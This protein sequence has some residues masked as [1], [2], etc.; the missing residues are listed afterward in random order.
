MLMS[1]WFSVV[2]AET[3]LQLMALVSVSV[4]CRWTLSLELSACRIT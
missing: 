3:G 2:Y 4:V 1:D